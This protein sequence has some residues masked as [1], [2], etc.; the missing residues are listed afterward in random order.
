MDIAEQL[1]KLT[2]QERD[3]AEELAE[4]IIK[5]TLE[6][7]HVTK[8]GPSG[9]AGS[10][11]PDI[12]NAFAGVTQRVAILFSQIAGGQYEQLGRIDEQINSRCEEVLL[13]LDSLASPDCA[14]D[15]NVLHFL[16]DEDRW[17]KTTLQQVDLF[18]A[19]NDSVIVLKT[20]LI[21]R[22]ESIIEAVDCYKL[23]ISNR[24]PPDLCGE[25][26]IYDTGR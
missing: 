8:Y 21:C 1:S 18:V 25:A 15:Q 10:T 3:P 4:S 20:E 13:R 12:P 23:I 11:P 6:E 17:L 7:Q 24:P 9:E 5:L 22:L 14:V 26:N 16:E 19:A 2:L